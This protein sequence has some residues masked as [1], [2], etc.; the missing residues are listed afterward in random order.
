MYQIKTAAMHTCQTATILV[1]G[2]KFQVPQ[3]VLS[4]IF[5]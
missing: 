2:C 5:A 3:K 4:Q 1:A